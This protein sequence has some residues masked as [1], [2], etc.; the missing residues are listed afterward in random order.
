VEFEEF[1][2]GHKVYADP[3]GVLYMKL[4]EAEMMD[5]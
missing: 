4:V 1:I 3:T 5:R 2:M